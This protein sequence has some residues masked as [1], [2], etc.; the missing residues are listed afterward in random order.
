MGIKR[1]FLILV[2]LLNA[3]F[4]TG[5]IGEAVLY[6]KELKLSGKQKFELLQEFEFSKYEKNRQM[7]DFDVS[8]FLDGNDILLNGD[9]SLYTALS[10]E[11]KVTILGEFDLKVDV[12]G[13]NFKGEG[14][15]FLKDDKAYLDVDVDFKQKGSTI[16]IES[17]E[18]MPANLTEIGMFNIINDQITFMKE[19]FKSI[20]YDELLDEQKEILDTLL[21]LVKIHKRRKKYTIL[22]TLTKEDL[23]SFENIEQ[24][25]PSDFIEGI[26]KG[27]KIEILFVIKDS[28]LVKHTLKADFRFE[29]KENNKEYISI[30][31]KNTSNYN[32]KQPKFPKQ[33]ELDQYEEVKMF[34]IFDNIFSRIPGIGYIIS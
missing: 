8:G 25:I 17:K 10:P 12:I 31:L 2:M 22:L 30:K 27:S 33:K 29:N 16:N 1:V 23:L 3:V 14:K 21:D 34:S 5:C 7:I 6:G 26:K 24:T 19:E 28:V 9:I 15:F 13:S 11:S 4:L 18:V 32:P 20:K